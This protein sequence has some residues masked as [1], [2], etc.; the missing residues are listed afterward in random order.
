MTGFRT[1]GELPGLLIV[2]DNAPVRAFIKGC[3]EHQYRILEADNGEKGLQLA[4]L[5]T[6]DLVISD[7]MMPGMDGLELCRRLKNDF[8]TSHIP[9]I[10][11]TAKVGTEE[12]KAGLKHGA[13]AYMTKPF[14]RDE[15]VLRVDNL[16]RMREKVQEKYRQVLDAGGEA[17]AGLVQDPENKDFAMLRQ[18]QELIREHFSDSAFGLDEMEKAIGLSRTQFHRKITALTGTSAGQMLRRYRMEQARVLLRAR[19]DMNITEVAYA[20]GF[21]DANY[22]ST[23]FHNEF[24]VSPREYRKGTDNG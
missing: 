21:N 12:V 2:E 13:D 20:S 24:G 3:L 5:E 17:V 9:V 7:I 10:L 23:A 16:L 4:F 15:L 8:Q 11:L 19:T 18:L 6:P 14:D 22:F 1:S